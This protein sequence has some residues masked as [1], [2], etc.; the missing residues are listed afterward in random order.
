MNLDNIV[1]GI[2]TNL[3]CD[4][5]KIL[6]VQLQQCHIK[7]Q[8]VSC[9]NLEKSLAVYDLRGTKYFIF[10][11]VCH[12]NESKCILNGNNLPEHSKYIVFLNRDFAQYTFRKLCTKLIYALK[13]KKRND[14]ACIIF[15]IKETKKHRKLEA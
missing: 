7:H 15:R 13:L 9:Y 3:I 8:H 1:S 5:M 11:S 14:V 6:P 2:D 4:F 12:L 10:M